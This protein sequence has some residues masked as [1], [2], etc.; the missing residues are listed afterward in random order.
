MS[1]VLKYRDFVGPISNDICL[2]AEGNV[3]LQHTV[4]WILVGSQQNKDCSALHWTRE[5][6][7]EDFIK[8]Y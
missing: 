2:I 5:T 3:D 4:G 1:S 8:G 6:A 7:N